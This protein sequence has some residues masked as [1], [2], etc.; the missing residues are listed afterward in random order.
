MNEKHV[1]EFL[2]EPLEPEKV[3]DILTRSQQWAGTTWGTTRAARG[4]HALTGLAMVAGDVAEY[5]AAFLYS[6]ALAKDVDLPSWSSQRG[7]ATLPLPY[8][9]AGETAK[10]TAKPQV[11]W[12]RLQKNKRQRKPACPGKTFQKPFLMTWKRYW[13]DGNKDPSRL[14]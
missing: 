6:L 7:L 10:A 4:V 9:L 5:L 11:A 12:E 1:R 8:K 13:P 3:V 2:G 14:I